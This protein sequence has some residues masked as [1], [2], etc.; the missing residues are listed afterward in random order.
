VTGGGVPYFAGPRP[1]LRLLAQEQ[2]D[3]NVLK[4]SYVPA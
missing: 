4:L 3:E 1:L 2:I